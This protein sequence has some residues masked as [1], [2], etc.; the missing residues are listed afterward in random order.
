MREVKDDKLKFHITENSKVQVERT[1]V[2]E[3]DAEEYIR[4]IDEKENTIKR[5]IE[6]EESN[7]NF[8]ERDE[9]ILAQFKS[10]QSQVEA[11]RK[12]E[13]GELDEFIK[14]N[15]GSKQ[16]ALPKE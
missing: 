9:K 5:A 7:K 14:K 8:R 12:K 1:I 6:Q 4:I 10:V 2:E 16:S 15:S 11:I 13:M 3:F